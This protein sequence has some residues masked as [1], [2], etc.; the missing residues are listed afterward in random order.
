LINA[1]TYTEGRYSPDITK[2]SGHL[3]LRRMVWQRMNRG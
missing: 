2:D 3:L 1:A